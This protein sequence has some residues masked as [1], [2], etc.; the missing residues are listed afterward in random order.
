M[1]I[2]MAAFAAL[3]LSALGAGDAWLTDFEKAKAEAKKQDKDLLLKF[4][5]SDWCPPCKMLEKNILSKEVFLEGA[6]EDFVLV[7][8]DYPRQKELPE[9]ERKQNEMLAARYD[10]KAFPTMLLADETGLPY[11]KGGYKGNDREEYTQLMN[12]PEKYLKMLQDLQSEKK[13]M[14]DSLEEARKL[15]GKE[16]ARALEKVLT[17]SEDLEPTLAHEPILKEI[18]VADP[19]DETGIATGIMMKAKLAEVSTQEE[20]DAVFKDY[21]AYVENSGKKG[22]E[23]QELML[24]KMDVLYKLKDWDGMRAMV[25]KIVAVDPESQIGQGI[26]NVK[27]RIDQ[28]EAAAEKEPADAE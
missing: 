23:K 3:S 27:P 1:M 2:K 6:Q 17:S 26:A 16:K 21:D 25:D 7:M 13:E 14:M 12:D 8:L 22:L 15:E 9:A 19:D 11:A 18:L 5:G 20:A 4:T 24:A 10:V 28:M